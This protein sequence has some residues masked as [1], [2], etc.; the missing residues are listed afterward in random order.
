MSD[1]LETAF[2][3]ETFPWPLP[4]MATHEVRYTCGHTADVT[5]HGDA[6]TIA[7]MILHQQTFPCPE[8]LADQLVDEMTHDLDLAMAEM[9]QDN[10]EQVAEMIAEHERSLADA[11]L[12]DERYSDEIP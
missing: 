12:P 7:A 2:D 8:C 3:A 4:D 6:A 1:P 10:D 5:F 11:Q 9:L